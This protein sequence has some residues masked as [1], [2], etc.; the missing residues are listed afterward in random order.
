VNNGKEEIQEEVFEEE[1][2]II[3]AQLPRIMN[4]ATYFFS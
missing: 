1:E 4:G 3:I 2:A